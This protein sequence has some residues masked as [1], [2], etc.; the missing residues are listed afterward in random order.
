MKPYLAS[1][2]RHAH[3]SHRG[4]SLL[5]P[6]NTLAAFRQAV[7]RWDTDVLELDV[8]PTRDGAVV[9][10]HDETLERTTNGTGPV[11]E[12]SLAQ[13]QALDAGHHLAGWRG[14]GAVVPTLQEVLEAFP[15]K[16][17]NI[18]LKE[19]AD[20]FLEAFAV[21]VEGAGA[22]DRVCVGHVDEERAHAL[23]A[24]LP[25]CATF[26]PQD[27]LLRFFSATRADGEPLPD[28]PWDVLSLPLEYLG[29]RVVDARLVEAAHRAGKAVHV[30]TVDDPGD[31]HALWDLGVD[32][33]LTD[34]PD[35]LRAVMQARGYPRGA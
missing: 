13:L 21:V 2:P 16:H 27:P 22:V 32:S 29:L 9:V 31:M 10:F 7:E 12:H 11:C 25:E 28:E 14:R 1:L 35:V 3:T 19:G 8:R 15:G 20:A 18:E 33:I 24:R 23:R 30:W 34:R 5:A 17:V 6:E 4:G 26:F